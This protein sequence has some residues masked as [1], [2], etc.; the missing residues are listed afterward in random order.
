MSLSASL[1]FDAVL[2]MLGDDRSVVASLLTKF[3]A[4]LEADISASELALIER[5]AETL[6]KIAHRVK[7]TSANL[8]AMMLSASA[9]ELEQACVEASDAV[10]AVKQAVLAEQAQRV[11]DDIA[12]W[13]AH[14]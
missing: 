12:T 5:D 10:W 1:H 2:D 14:S 11:R 6:R 4:E 9:R 7:G 8:Q 3:S 13:I